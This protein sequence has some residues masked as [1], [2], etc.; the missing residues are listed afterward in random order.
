MPDVVIEHR[1]A[2]LLAAA[3][4]RV[5]GPDRGVDP[6]RQHPQLVGTHL[7]RPPLRL[8]DQRPAP[9]LRGWLAAHKGGGDRLPLRIRLTERGTK[10]FEVQPLFARVEPDGRG[11]GTV[12][13]TMPAADVEWYAA[14]FLGLGADAVVESPPQLV[15]ALRRRAAAAAALYGA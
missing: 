11:G 5:E 10:S 14:R 3:G 1:N 7:G 4:R 9:P 8:L 6:L 2:G 12:G 15:D 13:G